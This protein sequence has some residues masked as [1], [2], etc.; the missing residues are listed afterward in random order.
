MKK[1]FY[2]LTSS[3]FVSCSIPTTETSQ[4][5]VTLFFDKPAIKWTEA[6][7]IGNGRLGGMVYGGIKEDTIAT[8][9]DTFWSG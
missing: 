9:D 3:L 4:K 2:I 5:Q 1:Y 8:N 7:P 6:I